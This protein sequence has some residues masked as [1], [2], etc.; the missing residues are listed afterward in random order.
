MANASSD[1]VDGTKVPGGT[2]VAGGTA[3]IGAGVV[4]TLADD[5]ASINAARANMVRPGTGT[6]TSTGRNYGVGAG[7]QT[8]GGY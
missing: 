2:N 7:G 5:V 4:A 6:K 1:N 3:P 8:D